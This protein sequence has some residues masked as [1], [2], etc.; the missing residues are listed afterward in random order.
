MSIGRLEGKVAIITGG[1]SGIGKACALRFAQEGAEIV[2]AD[3]VAERCEAAA[4]EVRKTTN[5][6]ALAVPTNVCEEEDINQL[7]QRAMSEFGHIDVLV[8][9]A[10]VSSANYVSGD[11]SSEDAAMDTNLIN[12]PLASWDRVLQINLTGVMLSDRIVARQMLAQ[13]TPG[14]II[15]IASTAARVPLPGAAD[16][17]VSKAGVAMLTNVLSR[18]LAE[19]NIRVNAIGPGFI[20]TPMTQGLQDRDD[21]VEMM[22]GM[23]PLGRL[24]TALEIANTALF[25]ASEESTYTTGQTLY[26]NGGM[27]VG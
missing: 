21:G 7:A 12:L 24:G 15:N 22:V 27:W 13:G 1:A 8:A 11:T 19:H 2:I 3:L 23:T 17:C 16:Y 5:G 26:P 18:E 10:G 14:S 25:L 20:E 9:A 6:R 4:E